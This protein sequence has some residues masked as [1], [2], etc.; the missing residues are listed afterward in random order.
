MFVP[1]CMAD[2]EPQEHPLG[3]NAHRTVP[4]SSHQTAKSWQS[5]H[6]GSAARRAHCRNACANLRL[7][8]GLSMSSGF[9]LEQV[10]ACDFAK[11]DVLYMPSLLT[12]TGCACF[13]HGCRCDSCSFRYIC[14]Y[15]LVVKADPFDEKPG[16]GWIRPWKLLLGAFRQSEI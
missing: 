8:H 4:A 13:L 12:M 16:M 5:L 15:I 14:I 11:V 10:L 3:A 6:K 7:V 1:A 9:L 2:S